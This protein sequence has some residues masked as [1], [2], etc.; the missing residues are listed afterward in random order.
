MCIIG[1]SI[2][3]PTYKP[4]ITV[5]VFHTN[6]FFHTNGYAVERANLFAIGFEVVIEVLCAFKST[7]GKE[8]GDAV[9]LTLG[10]LVK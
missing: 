5:Q 6:V 9:C 4:C 8:L 7:G 10:M 3:D 1:S 2:A